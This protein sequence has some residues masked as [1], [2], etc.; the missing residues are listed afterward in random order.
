MECLI[1]SPAFNC[2]KMAWVTGVG[3]TTLRRNCQCFCAFS[4]FDSSASIAVKRFHNG[5]L[6]A[7]RRGFEV[8]VV[9]CAFSSLLTRVLIS[10]F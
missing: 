4:R 3:R 7:Q 1:H 10:A 5:D 9:F 2:V 6:S 8:F